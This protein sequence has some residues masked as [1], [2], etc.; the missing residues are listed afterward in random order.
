MEKQALRLR[1]KNFR[2]VTS[3]A[4]TAIDYNAR[5][6]IIEIEF[7]EGEV[8]HYLNAKKTEW[9][10]LLQFAAK[11]EGLGVYVNTVFK[12]PYENGER[13]YYKLNVIEESPENNFQK[14][15]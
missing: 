4:V 8:Y 14:Q 11:K 9:G 2:Y 3:R 6:K 10:T 7:R 5:A 1:T 15:H 12:K 13:K